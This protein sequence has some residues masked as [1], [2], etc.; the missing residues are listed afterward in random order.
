V[1]IGG[2]LPRDFVDNQPSCLTFS[3]HV[4]KDLFHELSK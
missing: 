1:R 4:R 2:P 3:Y